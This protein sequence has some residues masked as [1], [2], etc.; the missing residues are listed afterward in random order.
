M[1]VVSSLWER[2]LTVPASVWT[3]P[4]CRARAAHALRRGPALSP[5]PSRRPVV[6]PRRHR[7]AQPLRSRLEPDGG[8]GP[9]SAGASEAAGMNCL[10]RMRTTGYALRIPRHLQC[11]TDRGRASRETRRSQ[12][13]SGRV[14]GFARSPHSLTEHEA[15]FIA[16]GSVGVRSD[17]PGRRVVR[18]QDRPLAQA[19]GSGRRRW[20]PLAYAIC[21][22]GQPPSFRQD[23]A[24][25]HP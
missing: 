23:P 2:A 8:F 25:I 13:H 3:R 4:A 22:P 19:V 14:E 9:C 16:P 17:S 1:S 10:D 6:G 24:C 21:L 11:R 20:L 18:R 15:A 7:H 12:V 5:E